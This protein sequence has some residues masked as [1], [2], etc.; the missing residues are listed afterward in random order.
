MITLLASDD[1]ALP[2]EEQLTAAR[3]ETKYQLEP[4]QV[5]AVMAELN[6]RLPPHRYRGEG[7][8]RL[9]DPHHYITTVYFDTAS[10][11]HYLASHRNRSHNVKVRVREYYDVYPSLAELATKRAQVIKHSPWVFFEVKRRE[12][13]QTRKERLR[14][15]RDSARALVERLA[16]MGETAELAA[17][18]ELDGGAALLGSLR[19]VGAPL[20]PCCLVNY[21]RA[22]WQDSSIGLRLTLDLGI[23]Y[24]RPLAELWKAGAPLVR[25]SLGQ[26]RGF[27]RRAVL[28][29]KL[30]GEAPQWL[31]RLLADVRAE[32]SQFSKFLG[33]MEVLI[34]TGG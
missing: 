17:D 3:E 20:L 21:R 25:R 9:S 8:S 23:T 1:V 10:R 32:S 28:E 18:G 7:A 13:M 26:S 29:V 31:H 12:G 4:D 30:R 11:S 16:A 14:L 27:E 34:A 33:A 5:T 6:R 19:S 2:D 22:S 15:V 24:Y